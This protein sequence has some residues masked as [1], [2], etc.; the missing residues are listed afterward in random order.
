MSTSDRDVFGIVIVVDEVV[1]II[2]HAVDQVFVAHADAGVNHGDGDFFE[3]VGFVP[4]GLG[5]NM[6]QG[7]LPVVVGI[8]GRVVEGDADDEVLLNQ[9]DIAV[10][11]EVHA[12]AVGRVHHP[13]FQLVNA[14]DDGRSDAIDVLPFFVERRIGIVVDD[15]V[16]GGLRAVDGRNSRAVGFAARSR[17]AQDID[18]GREF[19]GDSGKRTCGED[20]QTESE[21][22]DAADR[23]HGSSLCQTVRDC[24]LIL[25]ALLRI[26]QAGRRALRVWQRL[27][28]GFNASGADENRSG[29]PHRR[30]R[31]ALLVA[32]TSSCAYSS[33]RRLTSKAKMS[34]RA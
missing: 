30:R 18:A 8:V 27:R 7:P 4:G 26:T 23:L 13:D 28:T 25:T 2:E 3:L 12:E 5:L 17:T 34:S 10:E 20:K 14:F 24:R 16:A 32:S 22:G 21:T 1:A 29:E 6:G 15:P 9:L 33:R 19:A 11:G 31:G